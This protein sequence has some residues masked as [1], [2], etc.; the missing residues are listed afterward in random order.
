V[1]AVFPHQI[2]QLIFLLLGYR[3]P[4]DVALHCAI[5]ILKVE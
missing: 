2:A 5:Q 3:G 1:I 4:S